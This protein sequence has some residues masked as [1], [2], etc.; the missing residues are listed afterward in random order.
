M[1][2]PNIPPFKGGS[3]PS[4]SI[5]WRHDAERRSL[6][7]AGLPDSWIEL[8]AVLSPTTR[9]VFGSFVYVVSSFPSRSPL[10]LRG[11][12]SPVAN[13]LAIATG[14]IEF[15]C[16][17]GRR[18]TSGCS[19]H[20][21]RPRSYRRLTNARRAFGED[22]HLAD[23]IHFRRTGTGFQP[24]SGTPRRSIGTP[25]EI[26]KKR[27]DLHLLKDERTLR[28]CW[29]RSEYRSRAGSPWPRWRVIAHG[30]LE[31]LSG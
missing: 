7:S 5:P 11:W 16:V 21:S 30:D 2:V 26:S 13:R 20:G 27:S 23:R 9:R 3:D 15:T 22:F 24:V 8:H 14:R 18:F 12:A 25:I 29:F 17:T 6:A 1:A 28:S 31:H 10:S 19:P 4:G